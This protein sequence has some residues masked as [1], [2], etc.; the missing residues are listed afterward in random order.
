MLG[1][2]FSHGDH[3]GHCRKSTMS[4]KIRSAGARMPMLR[5]TENS[6]GRMAAMMRTTTMATTSMATITS[7]ATPGGRP[8]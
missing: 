2:I 6:F 7:M 5:F 3:A 1:S 4:G 8:V